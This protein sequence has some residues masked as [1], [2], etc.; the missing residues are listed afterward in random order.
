VR[1]MI[2]NG[3][4]LRRGKW[5][6]IPE[7]VEYVIVSGIENRIFR[8]NR[9]KFDYLDVM[10]DYT[11]EYDNMGQIINELIEE[12]VR[13]ERNIQE[14]SILYYMVECEMFERIAEM[15]DREEISVETLNRRSNEGIYLLS[16][17][18]EIIHFKNTEKRELIKHLIIMIIDRMN[19]EA[20]NYEERY[21]ECVFSNLIMTEDND[22]IMRGLHKMTTI[23]ILESEYYVW[24]HL[25]ILTNDE[26]TPEAI[27]RT[28]RENE[29]R[30]IMRDNIRAR[31]E[32]LRS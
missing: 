22:I 15:I 29:R 30:A 20:M 11:E 21:E 1:I 13:N 31:I 25:Q 26:E 7:F 16:K 19:E 27:E 9:S 4:T 18:C 8:N 28:S 2:T 32:S 12:G 14:K 10:K 5:K 23:E 6:E 24:R 3:K 17:I